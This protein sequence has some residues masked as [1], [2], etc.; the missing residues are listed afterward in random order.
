MNQSALSSLQ[1]SF[2]GR[3]VTRS[4]ADYDSARAV[5][6][7]IIDRYPALIARCGNENDVA[8]A[9]RFAREHELVIAVR[10]G[11]HSVGG[12]STCDDGIVIDLSG[13][14]GVT[15]DPD[16]RI[17]RVKGGS[18]LGDLDRE[19]QTFGLACPVGVVSHTGVAGLTLGGGMGRLQRKFGFTVDN[20]RGVEMIG[21]DGE[22]LLAGLDENEEL[23]WGIRGAGTNFGIAT[24]FEYSLHPVGP[25]VTLAAAAYRAD[26][27]HDVVERF[28][29]V[30]RS[31]PDELMPTLLISTGEAEDS[32]DVAGEPI[33]F[34][35]VT[36]C[37]DPGQA[38][39]DIADLL[40]GDP[41]MREVA[42][43]P[44][45]K[46]QTSND[47]SLDW[48]NRFYMK[49]G[50]VDEL[51][52]EV[53]DVAIEA[54]RHPPG[55]CSIGFWTQGGAIG[56][57]PE[58][59][60]AFTGR[61]AGFWVGAEAFWTS[62]ENDEAMMSW[63]RRTWD[64]ITPFTAAGHYVNDMVETGK[65]IVQSIYG[66]EKYERLVSLKR[67]YDPENVFRLNQNIVP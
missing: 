55:D 34:V 13:L 21:A 10:C 26:D 61:S 46:V 36:H 5:W 24:T 27:A 8:A 35:R 59:A 14:R 2:S 6:N 1:R 44:Y 56:R 37:G 15:V 11:G 29:S 9:I 66:S 48:G 58:G 7:G 28:A 18:L 12:F 42:R 23:F 19:A 50:F 22:R 64:E 57:V 53:I 20:L 43:V 54:M 4:D 3:L 25:D 17:A 49:G 33:I 40:A 47:A 39:I 51:T 52:P 41:F 62:A 45:L 63:G 32:P 38:E 30:V 60:M 16:R 31:A 65:D 67:S